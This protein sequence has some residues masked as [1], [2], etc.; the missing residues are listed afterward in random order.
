MENNVNLCDTCKKNEF[1]ECE[2]TETC[3][4]GNAVGNDNVID[5]DCYE[6]VQNEVDSEEDD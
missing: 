4:W 2:G 6:E 1:A 3:V 5:C